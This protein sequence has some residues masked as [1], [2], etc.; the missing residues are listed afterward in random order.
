M[1]LKLVLP[2]LLS[3]A[4]AALAQGLPEHAVTD[5]SPLP[6]GTRV[7]IDVSDANLSQDECSA[8]I[9]AYRSEGLPEG[10]V[11]VHKP[12]T[13]EALGGA[14]MPFCIENFDGEGVVFD[15][16]FHPDAG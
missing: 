8:L 7:Q 9:E 10:Q 16:T 11:S 15:T 12:S 2:C 3:G 4:T 1:R 13:I 6:N 5:R 14:V